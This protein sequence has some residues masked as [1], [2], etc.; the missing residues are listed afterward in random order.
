MKTNTPV[1]VKSPCNSLH[2]EGQEN[3]KSLKRHKRSYQQMVPSWLLSTS[4]MHMYVDL[5]GPLQLTNTLI[6]SKPPHS[7]S[8]MVQLLNTNALVQLLTPGM[9][10]IDCHT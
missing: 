5:Q 6:Q 3:R 10:A 2:G 1:P 9:T 8:N 4:H 7:F